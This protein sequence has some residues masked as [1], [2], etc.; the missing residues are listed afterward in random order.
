KLRD[1][2]VIVRGKVAARRT[3]KS[4]DIVLYHKPGIPLAVIEAK[5]NK[6]EIGKGMQQGIEYARLLDVPFV[7]A[8]N[9]DGFIFR[10]ATAAEGE[11][12]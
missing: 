2:K 1:G 11:C 12:L 5:A 8:T 4:A 10:D 9:G 3:V 6:H 7:F